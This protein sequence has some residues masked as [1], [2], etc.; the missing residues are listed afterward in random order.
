MIK[1]DF[2]DLLDNYNTNLLDNLRGFGSNEEYLKFYVPGTSSIKSFYNLI[3]A[4][5]ECQQ[6][7]FVIFYKQ[8][9]FEKK[10][11]NEMNIFLGKI[12]INKKI[13]K[14]NF[15]NLE[16]KIDKILY[17][18]FLDQK[19]YKIKEGNLNKIK[20]NKIEAKSKILVFKSEKKIEQSYLNNIYKIVTNNYFSKKKI[21][22]ENLFSGKID[23]FEVNFIIENKIITQVFHDCEN[24]KTLKKLLDIF[25]DICINKDIQEAAEHSVKYLEEKIRIESDQ[26]IKPGIILPSHAGTYF[27]DLNMMIRQVFNEFVKKNKIEFGINKNYFKKSY[28]WIN[29]SEEVKIQ[30]IDFI[31]NQI[32][33]KYSL[34]NQ[35]IIVQSINSNF[36]VNLGINKECK[37]LQQ[38]INIL[39]EIEIKL[40]KLDNNLEVFVDEVLDKNKLRIKNSPQAKLLSQIDMGKQ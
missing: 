33:Q 37:D 29:L 4:F 25:F 12:S 19:K 18:N 6:L 23:G 36:K 16:I 5:V 3:D 17:K 22:H 1:I 40:K 14:D 24:D 11:I 9:S 39:L 20:Q 35:S 38:K 32:F 28:H 31:L 13:I 2:N 8:D 15:T 34:T 21:D 10:L 26:L 27:D 7:E 30:K